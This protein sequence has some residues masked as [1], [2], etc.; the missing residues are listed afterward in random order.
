VKKRDG[1]GKLQDRVYTEAMPEATGR[2]NSMT[3][4]IVGLSLL[5]ASL[6]LS[7]LLLCLPASAQERAGAPASELSLALRSRVPA[8]GDA[9]HFVVQERTQSWEAQ[10]TAL[11]LC[12]MWDLHHCKRA[13]ERVRE[14]A[15][16]MNA[17][18]SAARNRGVFII[19]APS[20][21]M[22]AYEGTPMRRRAQEAP[23]AADLPADIG[24]GCNQLPEETKG[25]YPIDQSDG[26]E[27]DEPEEHVRWAAYLISLGRNPRAPWKKETD[28]LTIDERD[29]ITDSG[30]EVWNMLAQRGIE[31]VLLMGVH[32]NMCVLGRPFGLRQ[33]AKHGRQVV[34]V[35]DMTDTMYNPG[36]W[37]NVSH[38]RGTDLIIE[39]IEKY[40]C[41]TVTSDQLAG[42]KPFYFKGSRPPRDSVPRKPR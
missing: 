16:R 8:P 26:G 21:C 25:R 34:L 2:R 36:R 4:R 20:E 10:K 12:D 19:H 5:S 28:L 31:H 29:A 7:C 38:F 37:P 40:V 27:D 35:R 1:C 14:M 22:A 33:L 15:P 41:P 11:I 39:H 42:S 24:Q 17:V 3:D 13:V 32:T 30:I 23:K 9:G 6:G 18:V